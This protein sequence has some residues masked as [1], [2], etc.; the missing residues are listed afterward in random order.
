[1]PS[2]LPFAFLPRPER[3]AHGVEATG[4]KLSWVSGRNADSH[5]V[6]FGKSDPPDFKKTQQE[7]VFDPGTLEP[8]TTYFWRIDEETEDGLVAGR[9]WRFTTGEE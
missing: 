1:M 9:L 5:K 8:K 6:Y 7:N 2:V 3:N 4:A